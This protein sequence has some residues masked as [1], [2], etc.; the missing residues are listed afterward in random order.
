VQKVDY[1]VENTVRGNI[2][3]RIF[4]REMTK[5]DI[6]ESFNHMISTGMLSKDSIGLI[7]DINNSTLE[8]DMEDLEKMIVYI[9]NDEILSNIKIAVVGNCPNKI[10]FPT[11]ANFKL[12]DKFLPFGSIEDAKDWITDNIY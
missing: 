5:R 6:V 10:L 11:L 9:S 2:V 1:I 3:I 4:K 12:G 7:T 8:L